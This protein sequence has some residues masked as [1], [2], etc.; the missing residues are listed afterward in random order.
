MQD[1][2][3]LPD[4]TENRNGTVRLVLRPSIL[5]TPALALLLF[6]VA[7]LTMEAAARWAFD[8]LELWSPSLGMRHRQ[9]EVEWHRLLAFQHD[10]AGPYCVFLGN[11]TVYRGIDPV[12]F[13][14]WFETVSGIP[15]ECFTFGVQGLAPN[16]VGDVSQVIIDQL[17]PALLVYGSDV[18]SLGK[19]AGGG[20]QSAV[21]ERAWF[22]HR[23][24]NPSAEGWIIQHSMLVRYLL[25]GHELLRGDPRDWLSTNHNIEANTTARGF[26]DRDLSN[27]VPGQIPEP[28]GEVLEVLA[29]FEVSQEQ[30][31]GLRRLAGLDGPTAVLVVEA[32]LHPGFFRFLGR[33]EDDYLQAYGQ[34]Q[35]VLAEEGVPFLP[36]TAVVEIENAGWLNA[37]HLNAR[38]AAVFSRWLAEQ[39]AQ[40]IATR[41]L[42]VRLP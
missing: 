32:P 33:E 6:I 42:I 34:L 3:P 25:L 10:Q 21:L 31:D 41:Q 40:L 28:R 37:N 18:P 23:I 22:Q 12:I 9:F 26:R 35:A 4:T 30:L 27:L 11:S 7:G 15:L 29:A 17:S 38:G 2:T 39:V 13:S 8:H 20:P 24:G 1:R 5:K 16:S 19:S 14:D 36:S